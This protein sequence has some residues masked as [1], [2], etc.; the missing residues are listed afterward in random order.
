MRRIAAEDYDGA[1]KLL[2]KTHTGTDL[3][4]TVFE[5]IMERLDELASQ[6][7][8]E[9]SGSK[10]YLQACFCTACGNLKPTCAC[11]R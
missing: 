8:E 6:R 4:R 10:L 7:P 2:L 9:R 11:V 1:K 5:L 3:T